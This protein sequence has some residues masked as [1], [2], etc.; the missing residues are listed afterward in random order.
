M[1]D[2]CHGDQALRNDEYLPKLNKSDTSDGNVERNIAYR[3]RAV[4][5][6]AT[7]FTLAG[8][9]GLAFRRDPTFELPSALEYVLED[10]DGAAVNIY[11]QSQATLRAVIQIGRHGLYVDFSSE[12]KR[13]IIK[14]YYAEDVI[15][16]RYSLIGGKTVLTLLV[17]HE[18]AEIVT[19]YATEIVDQ[20]RELAIENG[21]CICRIWR[22]NKDGKLEIVPIEDA[23]GVMQPEITLRSSGAE[24]DFIPFAFAGSQNN[25]AHIDEVPLYGLAQV[26]IAH[27]RNSADYEDSVFFVGQ[28]QPWIS[29]LDNEW[30]DFLQASPGLYVGSR[31]TV[32]LP[33]KGAYGFAQ[34]LPNTLVKE[35]MDQKEAQMV[36]LGAR[37]INKDQQSSKTATQAEGE[38][39]A[40]TSILATCCANVSDAYRLALTWCARYLDLNEAPQYKINQDFASV[41]NDP[42]M[43][44]ALVTAWQQGIIGKADARAF[45]RRQGTVATER[46]DEDIDADLLADPF[47]D[48]ALEPELDADGKPVLDAQGKPVRKAAGNTAPAPDA[49]TASDL[50][51]IVNALT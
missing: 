42:A 14:G 48:P 4:L 7:G 11:Q 15:N 28:A 20:W 51:P 1:R 18:K 31:S 21:V 2:V 23:K 6:S 9:L 29:G 26:N 44:T 37:L 36:A 24:L 41:S 12:L 16:W 27:F 32:L 19:G 35:A 13:P 46:T 49:A 10:V 17:L 34:P 5:L 22:K 3:M 30:R 38:R 25:D 43:I 40:S 47:I 50:T 45:L 8:M 33:E 39:E